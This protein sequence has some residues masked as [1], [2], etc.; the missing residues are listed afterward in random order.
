M[1]TLIYGARIRPCWSGVVS[2]LWYEHVALYRE[3]GVESGWMECDEEGR[4][5]F[6]LCFSQIRCWR[7][8][9]RYCAPIE[10]MARAIPSAFPAVAVH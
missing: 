9:Q 8:F 1:C 5:C 4:C 2:S 7:T 10:E 6:A 3:L